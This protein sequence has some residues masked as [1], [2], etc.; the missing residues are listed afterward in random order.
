MSDFK[1]LIVVI[2]FGFIQS[3]SAKSLGVYG[4]TFPVAELS[5]LTFIESRLSDLN[6]VDVMK[7]IE[8]DFVSE[9][10]Q[11]ANRPKSLEFSRATRSSTHFYEPS[12]TL[13]H[14]ILD[15]NQKVLFKKG[16]KVNALEEMHAY[17]PHW[18]LF[19]A[20]DKAQIL[21]ARDVLKRDSNAKVILTGGEIRN[22]ELALDAEIFFDQGGKISNQLDINQV[23]A[24][25]L[26][27][28]NA[29]RIDEFL[30]NESGHVL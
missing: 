29:L 22:A 13:S 7:K 11:H 9:V 15:A 19:N 17:K 10:S 18:L 20:D 28:G 6:N 23:P 2:L 14:D 3:I 12:I 8:S 30:I 26:R 27:V 24:E 1:G 16:L 21:W 4:Q 25:V 5:L